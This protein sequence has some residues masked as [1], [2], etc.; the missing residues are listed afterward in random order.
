MNN[1]RQREKHSVLMRLIRKLLAL[2]LIIGLPIS[3]FGYFF[4]LKTITVLG[5]TRNTEQQIIERLITNRFDRNSLIL[6]LKHQYLD[7]VKIPFVEKVDL[8]LVDNNSLIFHVYE[9]RV[10][11]C[12]NFMGDFL[13]FDKDGIVVESSPLL[14][15]GIPLIVGLQF[16][17]IILNETLEIQK[18]ELFDVILNLTQLIEKYDLDVNTIRFNSKYE[19]SIDCGDIKILLGKKSNYDEV[20]SELKNILEKADGMQITLDMRKYVKGTSTIIAKPKKAQN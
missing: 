7:E 13:Y 18:Q 20:L 2:M 8:E 4:H 12:V 19:V 10:T 11:G 15:E 3:A 9:K 17:K 14:I 1:L 5:T 6:Y 16:N